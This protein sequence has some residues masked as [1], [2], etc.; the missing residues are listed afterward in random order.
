[1]KNLLDDSKKQ[2][3]NSQNKKIIDNL[4]NQG[5]LHKRNKQIKIKNFNK[6]KHIIENNTNVFS[7]GDKKIND[8]YDN[9]SQS[10]AKFA[11]TI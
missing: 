1:M 7:E 10:F 4:I 6:K 5:K 3:N 8:L 11:T 9:T 2:N